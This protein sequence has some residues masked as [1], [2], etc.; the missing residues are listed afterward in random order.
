MPLFVLAAPMFAVMILS[1]L[2]G[3]N[4]GPAE[5]LSQEQDG[6][7]QSPVENRVPTKALVRNMAVSQLLLTLLTLTG[8]HVQIISRISSSYP[9]W[10]WYVGHLATS[11]KVE[12]LSRFM[13]I[14]AMVQ[15]GLFASF[16]PP[17]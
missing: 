16:L 4:S 12:Y 10:I 5:M 1:G 7:K 11:S 15:G 2:W 14:Y 6:V 9:V 8:A 13:V 3:L 17:A